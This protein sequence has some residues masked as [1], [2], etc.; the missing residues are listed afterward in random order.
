[1]SSNS[2]QSLEKVFTPLDFFHILLLHPDFR[3]DSIEM[4]LFFVTGLQ[5]LPQNVSGIRLFDIF[6]VLQMNKK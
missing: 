1:M 3:M 5:T 6:F 4:Y 2:I